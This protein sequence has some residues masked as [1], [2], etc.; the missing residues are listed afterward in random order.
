L[1]LL[2]VIFGLLVAAATYFWG[3]S[4]GHE[5]SRLIRDGLLVNVGVYVVVFALVV[6]QGRRISFRPVWTE[7]DPTDS[8]LRGLLYGG[9]LA[10]GLMLL[11]R[12]LAG[13]VVTDDGISVILS[14]RTIARTL[15]AILLVC[16]AAPWV[17]ELLF[18]GLLAESMRSRGLKAAARNSGILFALWHPQA[19]FP[20]L[21]GL[22]G[23]GP[24]VWVPFI[25]YVSMGAMFA[26]LYFKRGLKSSIAA[27]TAFNG[28]IIFVA[29]AVVGG[30][31]HIIEHNGV[32]A[33]VPATWRMADS[34]DLPPGLDLAIEGPSGSGMVMMHFPNHQRTV[35]VAALEATVVGQAD[36][37]RLLGIE[38]EP[39]SAQ[40]AD[41]PMGMALRLLARADGHSAEI[42]LV[43]GTDVVWEIVLLSG[44]SKRAKA[45]FQDILEH[46]QLPASTPLLGAT[47]P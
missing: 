22:L 34:A 31:T 6:Y 45:D 33:L 28:V 4:S 26:R 46:M 32:K 38:L 17:E 7:G 35:D 8:L 5:P 37:L 2:I 25:Y 27:H 41:F 42:V 11:G 43:P 14:E 36:Q 10:A 18:R 44:G 21:N 15:L 40:R 12:L 16:V 19:V 24:P 30:P 47:S 1:G 29:L 3:R 13:H 23:D 39:G 20:I 9:G